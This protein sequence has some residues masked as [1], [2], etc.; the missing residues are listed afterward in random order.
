MMGEMST[1]PT[2]GMSRRVGPSSHSVGFT[3]ADHGN[4]LPFTCVQRQV[5]I[6][7]LQA[8]LDIA[9]LHADVSSIYMPSGPDHY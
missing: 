3:A 7:Q 4:F 6:A 8:E 5:G 1:P 2:G 9:A